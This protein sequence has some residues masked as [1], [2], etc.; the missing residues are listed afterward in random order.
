M[1]IRR[2]YNKKYYLVSY[3]TDHILLLDRK[4]KE[5]FQVFYLGNNEPD[6][7]DEL[8][9]PIELDYQVYPDENG[10]LIFNKTTAFFIT[11]EQTKIK[12]EDLDFKHRIKI[13]KSRK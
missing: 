4:K 10:F 1:K 5:K 8:F 12:E 13:K 11:N 7:E 3:N 6:W 9:K 2:L